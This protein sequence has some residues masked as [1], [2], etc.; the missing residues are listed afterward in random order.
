MLPGKRILAQTPEQGKKFGGETM[1]P[2][3]KKERKIP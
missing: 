3:P 2:A 1:E